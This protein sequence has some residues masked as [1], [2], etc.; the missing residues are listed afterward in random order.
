MLDDCGQAGVQ[1]EIT[2]AMTAA[3]VSVLDDLISPD[4]FDP[5]EAVALVYRAMER[6]R[7]SHALQ[8]FSRR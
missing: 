2:P 4:C 8:P 7:A 6:S 5:Y 3:G 1:T